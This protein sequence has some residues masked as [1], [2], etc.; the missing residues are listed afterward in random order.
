ME[1]LAEP[2]EPGNDVFRL[3]SSSLLRRRESA[4]RRLEGWGAGDG[5][6]GTERRPEFDAGEEQR[7]RGGWPKAT[8]VEATEKW[9][10][11]G[12][13]NILPFICLRQKRR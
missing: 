2:L 12:E 8:G 3:A 7:L 11:E 4:S 9:G 1:D 5:G 10:K 13:F 6:R